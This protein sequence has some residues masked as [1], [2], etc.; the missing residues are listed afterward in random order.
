ML[1]RLPIALAFFQNHITTL[2]VPSYVTLVLMLLA[3]GVLAALATVVIMAVSLL[4]PP[5]MTDGKALWVLRRVSPT[6]VGLA[7]EDIFFD[8]R[9]EQS[10]NSI[11][12]AGW[13]IP[14]SSANG[15]VVVMLHGYSDA[16]VGVMA[17]APLWHQLGFNILAIDLR[18]HGASGGVCSTAGYWER[19]DVSQVLNQ[20]RTARPSETQTIVLFGASLGA[21]VASAVAAMRNDIDVLVLDSPFPDF[22]HT[23]SAHMTRLGSP[24]RL[25]QQ[26]ALALAQQLADANFQSMH[27][28]RLLPTIE[29]PIFAIL[30]SDDFMMDS[31]DRQEMIQLLERHAAQYPSD[32]IWHVEYCAHLLALINQP[33]AYAHRLGAFLGSVLLG[34]R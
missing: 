12:I 13:W 28:S 30:P 5:R 16:K 26:P 34:K 32:V 17:W 15:R 2:R 10:G 4:R 31:Q 8:V 18:A 33:D 24:G 3:S 19:H 9:D 21:L 7:W 1:S 11:R 14:N 22:L 23:A 27:L 29:A 6:D 20:I 25:L